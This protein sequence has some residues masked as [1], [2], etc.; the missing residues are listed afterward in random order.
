MSLWGRVVDYFAPILDELAIQGGDEAT[1]I[2][3]IA[4]ST[5]VGLLPVPHPIVTHR[6]Q[7]SLKT[8]RIVRGVLWMT[9]F[10]RNRNSSLWDG[11]KIVLFSVK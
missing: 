9:I 7:R 8:S 6:I 4:A 10:L 1:L 3:H 5:L 2:K 11:S